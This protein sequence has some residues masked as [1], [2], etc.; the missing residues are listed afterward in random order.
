MSV[1]FKYSGVVDENLMSLIYVKWDRF[2]RCV[3]CMLIGDAAKPHWTT[4]AKR[5]VPGNTIFAHLKEST[6]SAGQYLDKDFNFMFKGNYRNIFTTD[7]EPKLKGKGCQPGTNRCLWHALFAK[8]HSL[9][10]ISGNA[11]QHE[12]FKRMGCH[13]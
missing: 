8:A 2:L 7:V 13:V 11:R 4:K 3:R 10:I 12:I 9:T 6:T 5:N 1:Y